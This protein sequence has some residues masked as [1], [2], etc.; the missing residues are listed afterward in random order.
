MS[1]AP[2]NGQADWQRTAS[3]K[4]SSFQ[5]LNTVGVE[6]LQA[7][8]GTPCKPLTS[9]S[10]ISTTAASRSLKRSASELRNSQTTGVAVES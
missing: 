5:T 6:T 3:H 9:F 1:R 8:G 7:F 10:E 4:V 2:C